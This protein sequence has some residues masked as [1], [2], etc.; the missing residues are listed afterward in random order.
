M[1]KNLISFNVDKCSILIYASIVL[2]F[3]IFNP[4]SLNFSYGDGGGRY[5]DKVDSFSEYIVRNTIKRNILS[6]EDISYLP[7]IT[8]GYS[9]GDYNYYG[10]GYV[11]YFSNM[12]LQTMPATIIAKLLNIN[13][14]RK[15]EAYFGLLRLA[16]GLVFSFLLC[17]FFLNF[18]K[19]QNIKNNFAI[20]ILIGGSAGFLF[21]S[22]NLYFVSALMLMPATLISF[23]LINGNKPS[24]KIVFLLGTM[25]FLKGYEFA[26]VFTLLTAFS[27]AVFSNGNWE[28]RIKA[29]L[30]VF[31]I[32][33]L[34]FLFSISIHIA[35][36]SADSGWILSTKE[37]A[38]MAFASLQI[39]TKS[40]NGVPFPLSSRF[41][42]A[43]NERWSATAFSLTKDGMKLTEMNVIM[44]IGFFT[45]LR[46]RV[47][48]N[49]EKIIIAY[50]VL[51]YLS[52]YLLAYQHIMWHRMYDW[53]IFSLTL[54]LSFSLLIIIYINM[55]SELFKKILY[56]TDKKNE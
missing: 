29:F 15:L 36:I 46:L 1:P 2:F 51:G 41:V 9:T 34:S 25:F 37:S 42:D 5:A 30:I 54:G 35:I 39:R 52:W 40:L 56:K 19:S 53:Y 8:K 21:Y 27:A 4:Q 16:N 28:D 32:I 3:F 6:K 48:S 10:D 45:I 18:C 47:M 55:M 13:T 12:T 31:G 33:C 24:K 50:G 20:P 43:M 22:Q 44:L 17:S 23:Q 11:K 49:V 14:E 38:D 26:T 7:V